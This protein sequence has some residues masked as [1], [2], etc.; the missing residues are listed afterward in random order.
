MSVDL[1]AASFAECQQCD[2]LRLASNV[3]RRAACAELQG[4]TLLCCFGACDARSLLQ[5][6]QACK[7][8]RNV[9]QA[10]EDFLWRPLLDVDFPLVEQKSGSE[11]FGQKT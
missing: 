11:A 3:Q 8:W 6:T 10:N 4:D 2:R 1:I 5:C 9:I 7:E